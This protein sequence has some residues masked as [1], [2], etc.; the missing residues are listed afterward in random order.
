MA[1]KALS[2]SKVLSENNVLQ[3]LDYI[4]QTLLQLQ[5]REKT[6]SSHY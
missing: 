1:K 6:Y 2:I 5:Q 4:F 3:T